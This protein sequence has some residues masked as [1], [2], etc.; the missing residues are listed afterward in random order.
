MAV[1]VRMQ[2]SSVDAA[3]RHV[4]DSPMLPPA[5]ETLH[6]ILQSA[7][8]EARK[9]NQ[10][11]VGVEH[12]ALALLDDD[13]CEAVRILQQMNLSTG[14]VRNE[15]NHVLPGAKEPPII[16][17]NLPL[18]PKVQ[19]LINNAVV[20]A[21]AGGKEALASRHVLA[22]MLAEASGIICE[23][24]RRNGGDASELVRAL[25]ERDVTAE[26]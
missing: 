21:Q 20:L 4:Y 14:S 2:S 1:M 16:A 7:Q 26:A 13:N 25:R 23:S 19:R 12:L 17:G 3:Q 9:C 11:F 6:R 5:T 15:L 22:A 10:E 18:S 24:F 8:D